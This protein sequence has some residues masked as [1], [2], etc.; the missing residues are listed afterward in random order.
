MP[1][2]LREVIADPLTQ[3]LIAIVIGL[4]LAIA[5]ARFG[6]RAVN[7]Y[8]DDPDSRYRARKAVGFVA[9]LVFAFYVS[10]VFRDRL[11]GL[12]LAFG[13]IAAGVAF[14]LQELIAS[15]AG[16]FAL[17]GGRFFRVG[18]RIEVGSVKG[19]VIDV[20]VLRT[21]LMEVGQWVRG[22][23]YSGRI[24]H[25]A[26]SAFFKEPVF[27]YS[28]DFPF[29][30]DE[31]VVPIRFSSNRDRVRAMLK[32]AADAV[33]GSYVPVAASTWETMVNR[34][35]IEPASVEP[36]ITLVATDNWLEYTLRYVVDYRRRRVVRDELFRHILDAV[37]AS[38]GAITL[39]SATFEVVGVPTLRVNR[40]ES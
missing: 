6:R 20:G 30:W 10:L 5:A 37:D 9:F 25:V 4:V 17:L 33:V 15:I 28:A 22:D 8:V 21:T 26:N 29:L 40:P 18:D 14:A 39:A 11:G 2:W 32:A 27:N 19:D 12:T 34:Y 35:R 36:M 38:G 24:V 3:R 7:R 31:I 16:W 13:I 1:A 23:L